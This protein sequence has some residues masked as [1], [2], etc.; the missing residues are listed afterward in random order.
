[1]SQ[2][3]SFRP[4]F[5]ANNGAYV[6][7]GNAKCFCDYWM[8]C[9]TIFA[10][11]NNF[12]NLTKTK[13]G[14]LSISKCVSMFLSHVFVIFARIT[15]PKMARIYTQ[16]IIPTGAVM[17]NPLILWNGAKM[18][19]PTCNV[20]PNKRTAM[21]GSKYASIRLFRIGN[22]PRPEPARFCFINFRPEAL[23]ECGRKSLRECRVVGQFL[24]R[25]NQAFFGCVSR[26]RLQQQREG[27]FFFT[28]N[29]L[30][31]QP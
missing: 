9:F 3:N 18:Y 20:R 31:F 2:M 14:S 29:P 5:A 25:H 12:N 19:N 23:S 1:M 6:T 7:S 10:N 15:K 26:S 16:R 17:E 4:T 28:A 21:A 11:F 22:S 8:W 13:F 27:T 30:L 24:S